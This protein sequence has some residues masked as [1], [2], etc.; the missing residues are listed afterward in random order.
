[1]HDV[2][3]SIET[4]P[5]ACLEGRHPDCVALRAV[6]EAGQA[7]RWRSGCDC[8]RRFADD[9]SRKIWLLAVQG[10]LLVVFGVETGSTE[11]RRDRQHRHESS[12]HLGQNHERISAL[13]TPARVV[14]VDAQKTFCS[15]RSSQPQSRKARN[16]QNL[17]HSYPL[18]YPR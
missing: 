18:C 1:M 10:K 15:H 16:L 8:G 12:T 3:C 13:K 17:Q 9:R 2:H 14:L 11:K 7:L 6:R 5:L 4:T